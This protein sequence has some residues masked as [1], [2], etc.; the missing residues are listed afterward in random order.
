MHFSLSCNCCLLKLNV[1]EFLWNSCVRQEKEEE[2]AAAAE[3]KKPNEVSRIKQQAT[4]AHAHTHTYT[5]KHTSACMYVTC[6]HSHPT[7][8]HASLGQQVNHF[9]VRI[10]KSLKSWSS[11]YSGTNVFQIWHF[12]DCVCVGTG[13]AKTIFTLPK[14]ADSRKG[15]A[16]KIKWNKIRNNNK[17][18]NS[19]NNKSK[20]TQNEFFRVLSTVSRDRKLSG[21]TI[22]F[23]VMANNFQL[24]LLL[25]SCSA[26]FK[27]APNINACAR[28][29]SVKVV[30]ATPTETEK[31]RR[32]QRQWQQLL[33]LC[34]ILKSSTQLWLPLDFCCFLLLLLSCGFCCFFF[35]LL[36]K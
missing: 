6:L 5:G 29:E 2:A 26:A 18:N 25:I 27:A 9:E 11:R 12:C 30:I 17:S 23:F 28:A 3:T 33:I 7:P 24:L 19:S 8:T 31:R 35:S 34:T 15:A 21:L 20:R 14:W 10:E 22:I 4:Q 32:R 13:R 1:K 16:K 36:N